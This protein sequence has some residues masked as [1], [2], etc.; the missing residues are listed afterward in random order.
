MVALGRRVLAAR[1]DSHCSAGRIFD[2]TSKRLV[3]SNPNRVC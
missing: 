1:R 2:A 3:A